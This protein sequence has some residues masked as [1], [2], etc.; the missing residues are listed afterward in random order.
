MAKKALLSAV[1]RVDLGSRRVRR[2]RTTGMVPVILYG[3][4]LTPQ[5]LAAGHKDVLAAVHLGARLLELSLDGQIQNALIKEVQYDPFGIEVLHLD[6]ARVSLD[7]RV[8]V[9][10]P[11]V[12]RGKP[13]G[14]E[15]NGVLQQVAS[16]VKIECVVSE[17][18]DDIRVNVA[19][20]KVGDMIKA[21]DIQLPPGAKLLIDGE[22][23]ICTVVVITEA[24]VAVATPEEAAAGEP[25][26][27]REKKE[28]GEEGAAEGAEKPEKK[29]KKA[30]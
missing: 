28:E 26:V 13:V 21:K 23:L 6:L 11:I 24:E 3:H 30:E 14:T 2:L 8:E 22:I 12:L 5:P 7:E 15:E 16:A 10:V 27:I 9:T 19:D 17:I 18:P 4:G 20:L 1:S 29:E 25:E